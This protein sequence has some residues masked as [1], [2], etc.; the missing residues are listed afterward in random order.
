MQSMYVHMCLP[1]HECEDLSL[2]STPQPL[3]LT[4]GLRS[5]IS[6]LGKP[7]LTPRAMSSR[8]GLLSQR[9]SPF[10]FLALS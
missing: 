9:S 5:P 7:A 8:L 10:S 1:V 4:S 6:S 3:L 2:S